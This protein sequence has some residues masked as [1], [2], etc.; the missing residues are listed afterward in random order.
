MNDMK[1]GRKKGFTLIE[2]IVSLGV[3]SIVILICL[4]AIL[5][6]IRASDYSRHCVTL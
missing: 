4:G 2:L 6:I 3:F 5:H 1:A